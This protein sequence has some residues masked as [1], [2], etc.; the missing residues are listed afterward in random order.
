MDERTGQLE[1]LYMID[2]EKGKVSRQITKGDWVVRRVLKVDEDNQV[3]YFTAS[4]V[5]PKEDPYMYITIK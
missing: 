2:M 5:N 4:G 1:H 3:I